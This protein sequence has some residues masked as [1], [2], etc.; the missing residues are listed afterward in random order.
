MTRVM[1]SAGM[2]VVIATKYFAG[3]VIVGVSA[4]AVQLGIGWCGKDQ[5]RVSDG[6][7]L[8]LYYIGVQGERHGWA[9]LRTLLEDRE[10]HARGLG[11]PFGG[12]MI[13]RADRSLEAVRYPVTEFKKAV[14]KN[15]RVSE[16]LLL[17]ELP[18][19]MVTDERAAVTAGTPVR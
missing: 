12:A 5:A 19:R 7:K 15:G 2:D 9:G 3:A 10:E 1:A 6:L 17:P 11:I 4:G 13:Y 18:V 8:V 14:K 16:N